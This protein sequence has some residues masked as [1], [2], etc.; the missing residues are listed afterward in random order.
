MTF[1]PSTPRWYA[2]TTSGSTP[3]CRRR[4]LRTETSW[5][6]RKSTWALVRA[7]G[8]DRD[9]AL[10][11][12]G[13]KILY[14]DAHYSREAAILELENLA[15]FSGARRCD[16]SPVVIPNPIG[17]KMYDILDSLGVSMQTIAVKQD[18][19]VEIYANVGSFPQRRDLRRRGVDVVK[20][21]D[22]F[23]DDDAYETFV[24]KFMEPV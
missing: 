4:L 17:Q 16:L 14:L 19:S 2:A 18:E 21:P 11:S 1:S 24:L 5:S 8:S 15:K 23:L 20:Y 13:G 7:E 3:V 6:T 9:L 10:Y 22:G 12:L